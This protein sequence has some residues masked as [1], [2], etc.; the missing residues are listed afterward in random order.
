[1]SFLFKR[2][3]KP[4]D[5]SQIPKLKIIKG[6]PQLKTID[7]PMETQT[8]ARRHF[9]KY[10]VK[11]IQLASDPYPSYYIP[12]KEKFNTKTT[13]EDNYYAKV[14]EK[15][16]TYRPENNLRDRNGTIDLNSHYRKEFVNHGLT[17]CEAKAFLLADAFKKKQDVVETERLSTASSSKKKAPR[18]PS[19]TSTQFANKLVTQTS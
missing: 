19:S 6:T 5:I 2:D 8:T 9:I 13:N 17:M 14:A 11:P 16:H 10:D 4:I 3:F 15:I 1:M 18:V 7:E 12:S